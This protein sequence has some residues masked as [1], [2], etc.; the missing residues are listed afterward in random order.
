[1]LKLQSNSS[2]NTNGLHDFTIQTSSMFREQVNN[3]W[4][5]GAFVDIVVPLPF[6]HK[7][8]YFL[9]CQ[10]FEKLFIICAKIL[11]KSKSSIVKF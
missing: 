4:P 5:M 9:F 3:A 11:I 6:R 10:N 1:M 7:L 8:N 2:V